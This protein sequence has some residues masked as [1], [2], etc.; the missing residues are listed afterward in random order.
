MQF[1]EV[2]YL[3]VLPEAIDQLSKGA[4]LT[5]KQDGSV[6][7]MTIAWGMAGFIWK[8]PIFQVLVRE[9]RHTFSMIENSQDFTVSIPIKEN[10]KEA[11]AF[12]GSKSGRDVDKIAACGLTLINGRM[13][14]SP[15]I[16]ECSLH[17][18]CKI[19]AKQ[20]LTPSDILTDDVMKNYANNDFHIMYYGENVDCYLYE[21]SINI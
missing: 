16:G 8:R 6:N 1:K 9:S 10:L 21:K 5:V 20:R 17:F 15:I 2:S 19:V 18:E 7:T 14:E 12:C 3:E 11:L 13:V 4:F